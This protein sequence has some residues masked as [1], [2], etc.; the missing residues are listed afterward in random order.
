[1]VGGGG[2]ESLIGGCLI[3]NYSQIVV[4]YDHFLKIINVHVCVS[5]PE[6]SR[7][8]PISFEGLLYAI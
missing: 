5:D 7:K 6:K 2:G 4:R 8:D 3:F 1:M